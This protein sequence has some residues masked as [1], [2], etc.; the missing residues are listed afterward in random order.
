MKFV[1]RILRSTFTM[2]MVFVLALGV[3][4]SRANELELNVASPHVVMPIPDDAQEALWFKQLASGKP[5]CPT[6]QELFASRQQMAR[7]SLNSPNPVAAYKAAS[8]IHIREWLAPCRAQVEW[9]ASILKQTPEGRAY[10][11]RVTADIMNR[12]RLECEV[13]GSYMVIDAGSGPALGAQFAAGGY[14][15]QDPIAVLY[16]GPFMGIVAGLLAMGSV[17]IQIAVSLGYITAAEGRALQ[18]ALGAGV[19]G[20]AVLDGQGALAIQRAGEREQRDP[21]RP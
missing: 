4:V 8:A 13:C 11:A 2:V 21:E 17:G 19:G 16:L 7:E 5:I 15:A 18:L 6:V 20:L 1:W 9:A 3:A 12:L 10:L 14:V